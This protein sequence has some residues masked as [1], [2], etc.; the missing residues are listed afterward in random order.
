MAGQAKKAA[1]SKLGPTASASNQPPWAMVSADGTEIFYPQSAD[2]A[3]SFAAT[4]GAVPANPELWPWRNE[5]PLDASGT[6]AE[7]SAFT[8]NRPLSD[9]A[10]GSHDLGT[11]PLFAPTVPDN[12]GQPAQG[13]ALQPVQS[14]AAA[15]EVLQ[16]EIVSGCPTPAVCWPLGLP[17][18][19][20]YVTCVHGG[21]K[22]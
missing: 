6:V 11:D 22:I 13:V 20:S 1:P 7:S 14:I 10:P 2:E 17:D 12:S 3:K 15:P 16:G 5:V 9:E 21:W 18:D 4:H 19:C 8:D